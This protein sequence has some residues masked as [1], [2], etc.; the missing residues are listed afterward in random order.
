M[1]FATLPNFNIFESTNAARKEIIKAL[2]DKKF[3]FIGV[4]G[5]GGVG[6]TTLMQAMMK[7][8]KNERFFDRVVMATVSQNPLLKNIQNEI[9]ESW[10]FKLKNYSE[11]ESVG[12]LWRLIQQEKR[13]LLILD[14]VWEPL[15]LKDVG[16][17]YGDKEGCCVIIT[18]RFSDM[19]DQMNTQYKVEVK[20][21]SEANAWE[22]FRVST[23]DCVDSSELNAVAKEIAKECGD[24]PLA[25]VTLGNALQNKDRAIWNVALDQMKKSM[26][27]RI[28]DFIVSED[29]LLPYVL[30]E[31]IFEDIDNMEEARNRL[32]SVLD[33]LEQSC[34]LLNVDGKT[35]VSGCTILFERWP[36]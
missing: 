31:D 1:A 13:I 28:E 23:G 4:Y 34:L 35:Q 5:M 29:D 2:E 16:V 36:F 17:P 12:L 6:K 27:W 3:N 19:C 15:N 7:E 25:L 9:A 26:L 18:T 11:S 22:L 14:D 8:L 20:V 24:L 21:L 32:H 10:G 33:T 30:S